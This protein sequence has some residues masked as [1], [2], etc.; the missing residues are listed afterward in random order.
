VQAR[1]NNPRSAIVLLSGGIDSFACAHFL[2]RNK[3]GTSAAF[4]DYGQVAGSEE[5][6]ASARVCEFL[7]IERTVIRAIAEP[8]VRF[9]TGE[10]P[11]RNLA[12][13]SIATMFSKSSRI[14]ALGIHTGTGYFDCSCSF[15][16][17]ADRLISECTDGYIALFAPFLR[18][19]KRDIISYAR[20]EGLDLDLT[21]SCE[22][23]TMPPCGACSSCKDRSAWWC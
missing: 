6:A 14:V 15:A 23:G 5:M 12:L 8:A 20:S 19:T 11:V 7:G 10:I 3:F 13:L 18:W 2:L 22:A 1:N 4:V 21:Y 17:Q 9:D 16:E